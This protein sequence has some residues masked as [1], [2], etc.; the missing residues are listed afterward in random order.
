MMPSHSFPVSDA[1]GAGIDID[2][3]FPFNNELGQMKDFTVVLSVVG[4]VV[5]A[6]VRKGG[7][8]LKCKFC[9]DEAARVVV[10][11]P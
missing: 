11:N 6:M 8:D 2:N 3:L 7:S 9:A 10:E 5:H 1:L 4:G